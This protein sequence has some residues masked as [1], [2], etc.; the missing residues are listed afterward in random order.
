MDGAPDSHRAAGVVAASTYPPLVE[1][2]P[3]EI[4]QEGLS[5]AFPAFS[6]HFRW[7]LSF[8]PA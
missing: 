2:E 7:R 6:L 3:V 4:A 1:E 5:A 8:A